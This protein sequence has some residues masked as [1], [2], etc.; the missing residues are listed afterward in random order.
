MES[1]DMVCIVCPV[2]CRMTVTRDEDGTVR[3]KGNTCKRGEAYAIDEFTAPK[4]VVT[5]SVPIDG[6][7]MPL[8]S[9]K[10]RE[11]IPKEKI[12]AVLD[13]LSGVR[14]KAPVEIGDVVIADAADSGVDVVA[15]RRLGRT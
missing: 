14:V 4:R 11:P 9:V 10:T 2:G 1:K 15:T 3:V 8:L 13:A 5:S 6:A 7:A 12:T